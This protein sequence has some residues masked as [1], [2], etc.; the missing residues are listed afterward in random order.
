MSSFESVFLYN[1]FFFRFFFTN[2]DHGQVSIERPS[3]KAFLVFS[4]RYPNLPAVKIFAYMYTI[5]ISMIIW[6]VWIVPHKIR[7]V[8]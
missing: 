2:S 8:W 5:Y 7:G 1:F 6:V 3:S 4:V